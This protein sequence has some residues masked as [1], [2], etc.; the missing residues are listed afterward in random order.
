MMISMI[1]TRRMMWHE[2]P[3]KMIPHA[4]VPAAPI[5]AH[6]AYAVPIGIVF[7]ACDTQKKL[8]MIKMPV[9]RLGMSFVKPWLN[10]KAIVKQISKK[11]AS[12]R[13]SHAI[14]IKNQISSTLKRVVYVLS[15]HY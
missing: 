14:D 15:S 12:R 10:F 1:D 13:K 6:T 9:I 7:I 4:T 5:P 8:K 3:K 2:S 11:P